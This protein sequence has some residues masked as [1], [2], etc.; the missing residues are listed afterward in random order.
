MKKSLLAAAATAACLCIP[1]LAFAEATIT[2]PAT[3][4]STATAHVDVAVVVPAVLSLRVGTGGA[5]NTANATIDKVTFTVPA[6][7]LGDGTPIS[8]GA[9][10]GDLGNGALTVRVYSNVGTNVKLESAVAGP[11]KN[12]A[13]STIPWS[14]ISVAAAALASGTSGFT[15]AAITHPPFNTAAAG[16]TTATPTTLAAVSSLVMYEGMWTYS[17]S[18]STQ[19]P[20]GTYGNTVANNGRITYTATQL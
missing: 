3:T 1:S 13:G 15:N 11:L 16:G 2:T 18:N 9:T 10:D 17:Y 6:A 4:N 19:V 20:S 14:Q 12:A 5:L 7:N 8:A